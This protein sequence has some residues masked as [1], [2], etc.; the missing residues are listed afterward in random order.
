MIGRVGW[1]TGM[2]RMARVVRT[3]GR[4]RRMRMM[5]VMGNKDDDNV[6]DVGNRDDQDRYDGDANICRVVKSAVTGGL[7]GDGHRF[8]MREKGLR[9]GSDMVLKRL[10]RGEKTKQQLMGHFTACSLNKTPSRA[11]GF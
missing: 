1:M 3:L 2:M 9:G 10:G 11:P 7:Q 5:R 6:D 4:A 8:R